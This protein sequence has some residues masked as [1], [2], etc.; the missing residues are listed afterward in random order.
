MA[1]QLVRNRLNQFKFTPNVSYTVQTMATAS[2]TV[3]VANPV[4]TTSFGGG[5]IEH[6]HIEAA[7][8]KEVYFPPVSTRQHGKFSSL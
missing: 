8:L 6:H 5:P 3:G 2:G 1:S 7:K 4:A